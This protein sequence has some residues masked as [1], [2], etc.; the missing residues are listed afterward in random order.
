MTIM[1]MKMQNDT[2]MPRILKTTRALFVQIE[3]RVAAANILEMELE[4]SLRKKKREKQKKN[5]LLAKSAG[6]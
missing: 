5:S 2:L 4:S 3:K 1:R 6:L